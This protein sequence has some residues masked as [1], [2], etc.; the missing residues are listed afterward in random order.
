MVA[1]LHILD[2]HRAFA[3]ARAPDDGIFGKTDHDDWISNWNT[4]AFPLDRRR[5]PLSAHDRRRRCNRPQDGI[6]RKTGQGS[7]DSA[8]P[9]DFPI[10]TRE[11]KRIQMIRPSARFTSPASARLCEDSRP[12]ACLRPGRARPCTGPHGDARP[13]TAPPTMPAPCVDESGKG[14]DSPLS[15]AVRHELGHF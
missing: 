11:W 3:R 5:I 14:R 15:V 7:P 4:S 12:P 8:K 9:A 2:S 13:R 10:Q 1:R 6:P